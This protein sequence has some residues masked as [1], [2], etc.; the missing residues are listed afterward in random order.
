[1]EEDSSLEKIYYS[2]DSKSNSKKPKKSSTSAKKPSTVHHEEGVIHVE[3]RD[4]HQ[5][6]VPLISLEKGKA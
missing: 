6:K 2:R 1:V 3:G 4:N 5:I